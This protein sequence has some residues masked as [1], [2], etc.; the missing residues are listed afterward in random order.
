MAIPYQTA[1]FKS[2]NILAMAI[3][4]QP[5]N[6]I[7]HNNISGYTVFIILAFGKLTHLVDSELIQG[8]WSCSVFTTSPLLPFNMVMM[9][10]DPSTTEAMYTTCPSLDRV[11]TT[12]ES[13]RSNVHRPSP[14]LEEKL[15]T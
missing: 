9:R 5:P 1:K 15:A 2:A 4:A 14:V 13:E 12:P 10:L 11:P 6:L 7:T 3:W 8:A